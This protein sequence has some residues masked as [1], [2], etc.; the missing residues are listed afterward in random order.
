MRLAFFSNSNSVHLKEWAEY[1]AIEL[2]HDVTVITIPRNTFEYSSVRVIDVGNSFTAR[3]P[4][5][6]T[7]L[8]HLRQ[9]LKRVDPDLLIAYRV[10]SYG[11]LATFTGFRPLAMAAQGGDLVWPPGSRIG[12]FCVRHAIR[13]GDQFHAW[14]RNIHDELVRYGADPEKILTCSRGIDLSLF[15]SLPTKR[16]GELRI[17]MTRSLLPSYNVIQLIEAMPHVVRECPNAICEIAGDGLS[18]K[19]LESRARELG[20]GSHVVFHG[21]MSRDEIVRLLQDAHIYVSTTLTDGLPLSHFEAMASG[22]F[23]ICTDIPANRLW[24]RSGE[25]GFLVP[26]GDAEALAARIVQVAG[27]DRLR[28]EA[29]E[30]NR[31]MVEAEF[32]REI[33]MRRI[34]SSWE[35]LIR[36]WRR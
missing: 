30:A 28:A 24:I 4:G 26:I 23:P 27:G 34:E 22:A 18:R 19:D 20:L 15:P 17:V 36:R 9:T 21:R 29:I 11:F 32:D 12:E 14:S 7:I 3:K 8:P 35:Q 6:F 25:N 2:G 31:R 33:N 1:M 5:W 13:R 10:V 16:A